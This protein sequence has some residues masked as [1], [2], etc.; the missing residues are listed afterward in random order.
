M[1][2]SLLGADVVAAQINDKAANE[3]Y[4]GKITIENITTDGAISVTNGTTVGG[5]VGKLYT[6]GSVT[7]KSCVNSVS[8]TASEK[9]KYAGIIGFTK[10]NVSINNCENKG[11]IVAR[12]SSSVEHNFVAGIATMGGNEK[13]VVSNC[14][15]A[16]KLDVSGYVS[17]IL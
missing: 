10:A 5:I 12:S 4:N 14:N 7:V 6:K 1:V 9:G 8:V 17:H 11:A 15:N 16:A 13:I 2:G 3:N